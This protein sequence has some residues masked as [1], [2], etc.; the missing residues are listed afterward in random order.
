MNVRLYARDELQ[1]DSLKNWKLYQ[2]QYLKNTHKGY[3]IGTVDTHTG[4]FEK[5]RRG[6]RRM[7]EEYT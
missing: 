5:N 6:Q 2:N 4:Y 3:M 7:Q 1:R